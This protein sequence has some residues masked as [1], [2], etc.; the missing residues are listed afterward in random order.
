MWKL[1]F[2][3]VFP[4]FLSL[5]FFPS[6]SSLPV[7]LL[8]SGCYGVGPGGGWD[9]R[10]ISYAPP[11]AFPP[12]KNA[13]GVAAAWVIITLGTFGHTGNVLGWS[14]GPR[15]CPGESWGVPGRCL[16][17]PWKCP[18]HPWGGPGVPWAVFCAPGMS[19][20]S[21]QG[22]RIVHKWSYKGTTSTQKY[23]GRRHEALAIETTAALFAC[24]LHTGVWGHPVKPPL[25]EQTLE[26]T[27]L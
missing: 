21:S 26:S 7:F 19:P 25:F 14:V 16:G 11:K 23:K 13:T 17:E 12:P 27:S 3:S 20:R 5:G 24:G 15:G 22:A 1:V 18:G 6:Y 2:S 8:P 10:N 4:H 9:K